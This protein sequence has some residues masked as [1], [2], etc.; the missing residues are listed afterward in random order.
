MQNFYEQVWG[1]IWKRFISVTA[2]YD[3]TTMSERIVIELRPRAPRRWEIAVPVEHIHF[4]DSAEKLEK[5]LNDFSDEALDYKYQL[6]LAGI[7][8]GKPFKVTPR[9]VC[10]FKASELKELEQ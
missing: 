10:F 3:P 8:V 1:E 5:L 7:H 6:T 4:D 2:E 9:G